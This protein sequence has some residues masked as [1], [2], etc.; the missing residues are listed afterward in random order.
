[1]AP[2]SGTAGGRVVG[3]AAL[4][5]LEDGRGGRILPHSV[6]GHDADRQSGGP[7]TVD[8]ISQRSLYRSRG[9]YPRRQRPIPLRTVVPIGVRDSFVGHEV[10]GGSRCRYSGPVSYTHLTLPTICSV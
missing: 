1:M 6:V 10:P 5:H 2:R 9:R 8:G 4:G 3:G 7:R